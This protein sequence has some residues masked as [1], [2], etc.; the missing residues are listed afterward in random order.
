M[1]AFRR[2][3]ERSALHPTAKGAPTVPIDPPSRPFDCWAFTG[4]A[5]WGFGGQH[6][7][8]SRGH[9]ALTDGTG[10]ARTIGDR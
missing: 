8:R 7:G 3:F 6:A 4:R 5:R 10:A 9:S 1:L 2:H